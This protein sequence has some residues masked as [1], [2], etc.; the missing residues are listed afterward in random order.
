MN[1]TLEKLKD[2]I[3]SDFKKSYGSAIDKWKAEERQ[4]LEDASLDAAELSLRSLAGENVGAEKAQV[5]AQL[6]NLKVS[7]LMTA[8][9][10]VWGIVDGILRATLTVLTTG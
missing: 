3:L 9:K 6:A 2:R 5:D 7:A 4:L 8:S 1:D 10:A